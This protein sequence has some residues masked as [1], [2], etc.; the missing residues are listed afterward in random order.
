[1]IADTERLKSTPKLSFDNGGEFI[2]QTRRE[3]EEYLSARGTRVRGRV[4]LYA[5]GVVALV[6]STRLVAD[7]DSSANRACGSGCSASAG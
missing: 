6:V 3:V 7:S 5:K 1:M 4:Q 2:R